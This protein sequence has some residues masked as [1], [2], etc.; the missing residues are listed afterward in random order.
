M[1]DAL[2]AVATPHFLASE[3]AADVLRMGG[4]AIDAALTAAAVLTVVYPHQCTAAG[5]AVALVS[6]NGERPIVVN[7]SGRAPRIL[8]EAVVA[9]KHMPTLG[10]DSV[11]VPGALAAWDA[12][13]TGWGRRPLASSLRTAARIAAE[14]VAVS[15]S[16]ARDLTFEA[17]VLARDGGARH[18]FFTDGEVLSE[19]MTLRQPALANSLEQLSANGIADFYQGSL[20]AQIVAYLRAAGGSLTK[21]DFAAFE[22]EV[23]HADSVGFAGD[24]Y[25]A[26]SGNTQGGYFLAGLAALNAVVGDLGA[27]PNPLSDQSA[28]V[29]RVLQE[30][31]RRR[32]QNLGDQ[33]D[34]A[35][36]TQMLTPEGAAALAHRALNP[37]TGNTLPQQ[38]APSQS[39]RRSG[40]TVAIVVADAEGTWVTLIQSAY[41]AFGAGIVEPTTG[42]VLHNRGA[43]F[44]TDP[45][46]PN[47]LRPGI[48]PPHTLMPVL[49]SRNDTMVGAHGTMGGRVQPQIQTQ[50]ALHTALGDEAKTAIRRPR[51]IIG[52]MEHGPGLPDGDDDVS[53]EIEVGDE[54]RNALRRATFRTHE[55]PTRSDQVGHAQ[56]VRRDGEH[57][58]SAATDPRADGA[59]LV[60]VR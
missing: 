48:R 38:V 18:L 36:L 45:S 19:G 22:A 21:E 3:S 28:I 6:R 43:A 23:T 17:G 4:N 57:D 25:F 53:A 50:L 8:S 44:S 1:A 12:L 32:D 34:D 13:A 41:Y 30:C 59:A 60:V 46:A 26:S 47:A 10:P 15:P 39:Y 54:V 51:W 58:F 35:S 9:A 7:G 27:V 55:L 2:G 40:D 16:L 20:G 33:G 56:M 29:A 37:R 42:F 31:G 49:V 11:T 5:D 14:G 24:R 52:R